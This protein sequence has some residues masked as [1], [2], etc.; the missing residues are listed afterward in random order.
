MK[1][2]IIIV[3]RLGSA[4]LH[5]KHLLLVNGQPIINFLI[6]RIHHEFKN[7]INKDQIN[8]I[9]ATTNELEDKELN[10]FSN[11]YINVFFGSKENIPLRQLEAAQQ[12]LIKNIISI[13]GDDI[14]CSPKGMR[15]VYFWLIKGKQYVKTS[16]LPFGMNSFG[17]STDYLKMSLEKNG[18]KV[19]ETGWGRI[20]NQDQPHEINY[21]KD[22][23]DQLLRF[24]LDYKEDFEMFKAILTTKGIVCCSV[25]DAE[26][27][28][29]V[30][31]NSLFRLNQTRIEEYWNN[32]NR[33]LI[34]EEPKLRGK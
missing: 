14:L 18:A 1:S 13:D 2:G 6:E 16:G 10:K 28:K 32:F 33:N 34:N 31:D 26:I 7:E 25:S 17:Y 27:I 8:I 4:R 29:I 5:K 30:I 22:K 3:A 23:K 19:L 12:F 11:E 20:F 21:K 9:I 24:S 15:E